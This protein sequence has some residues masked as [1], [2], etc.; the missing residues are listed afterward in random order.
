MVPM[1]YHA[2]RFVLAST[3]MDRAVD[4]DT[5]QQYNPTRDHKTQTQDG[6]LS[7]RDIDAYPAPVD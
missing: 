5:S 3:G 4:S 1:D 7:S 6:A 2:G